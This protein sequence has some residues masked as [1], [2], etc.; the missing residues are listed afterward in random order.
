[1]GLNGV[2][3]TDHEALCGHVEFLSYYND[4]IKDKYPDFKIGLGNEIYLTKTRDKKQKIL[5][6]SFT[7]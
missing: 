6:L 1:M 7:C 3:L 4:K 2:C 5:P